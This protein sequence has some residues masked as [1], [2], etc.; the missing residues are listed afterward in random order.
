MPKISFEAFKRL[1]AKAALQGGQLSATRFQLD[2]RGVCID[3]RTVR[4]T[5]EKPHAASNR[6]LK[7]WID[8][9]VPCGLCDLCRWSK[10][11]MWRDR[12]LEETLRSNR[13]WFLTLTARKE[14]QDY[15]L[16]QAKG[17]A[18]SKGEAWATLT[19]KQ[20]GRYLARQGW[21]DVQKYIKRLRKAAGPFCKIRHIC[22]VEFHKS[23]KP[24][25][26]LLIHEVGY[27]PLRKRLIEAC[28]RLSGRDRGFTNCKLVRNP[29]DAVEY[30]A[31]YIA[32]D[33]MSNGA[34]IPCSLGYGKDHTE[35]VRI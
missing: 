27:E 30:I 5:A 28:W 11:V 19:E 26:H 21:L 23:G 34:R 24:H 8:T 17:Y 32:K 16:V 22:V 31:K 2:V 35:E 20:R 29:V 12:M 25:F 14:M 10:R 3:P 6:V 15:W 9:A 18:S 7:V 4:F 13:T 33:G 1:A